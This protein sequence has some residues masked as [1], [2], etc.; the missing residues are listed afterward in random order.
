V[1]AIREENRKKK[2]AALDV[3]KEDRGTENALRVE[4]GRAAFQP[5]DAVADIEEVK[6]SNSF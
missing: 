5:K 4:E 1:I 2:P 6:E 3:D